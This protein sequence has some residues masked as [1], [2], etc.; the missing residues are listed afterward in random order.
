MLKT[1][2]LES[3]EEVSN[4]SFPTFG[5]Y[6]IQFPFKVDPI[7]NVSSL[8]GFEYIEYSEF[9]PLLEKPKCLLT[10]LLYS[11]PLLR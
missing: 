10:L 5:I 4:P 3:V 7:N 8:P 6:S 1:S 2:A 11:C 9:L